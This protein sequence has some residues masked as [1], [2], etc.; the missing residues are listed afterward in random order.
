MITP[1]FRESI[2]QIAALVEHL[3]GFD[4]ICEII[5]VASQQDPDFLDIQSFANRELGQ[6]EFIAGPLTGRAA[7]MNYGAAFSNGEHLLFLHCDTRL[8]QDADNLI[9][10][11]LSGRQWGR[12]D[13]RLDDDRFVFKVIAWFI[14][15]RSRLSK[16][17]TGD[18]AIFVNR[19]YFKELNGYPDQALMEDIEFSK[20]AK[21][22]SNPAFINEPAITSARRW[23]QDGIIK[24]VLLM[25]WLRALYW[26]GVSPERLAK[27]Y[28]QI[29]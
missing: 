7:Q 29:R 16:I 9:L 24:T 27:M 12:F 10:Q 13:V 2:A 28:R 25:W 22:K 6:I 15:Q 21:R 4:N 19:D 20:R 26:L 23:Q 3:S 17:S 14:N 8:P 5:I 1:V 11:A 18:Q